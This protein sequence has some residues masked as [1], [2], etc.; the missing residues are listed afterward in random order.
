MQEMNEYK[1]IS[2]LIT[3]IKH[4]EPPADFTSRVMMAIRVEAEKKATQLHWSDVFQNRLHAWSDVI[5]KSITP[6][7]CSFYFFLTAIYFIAGW[8]ILY[9]SFKNN[10]LWHVSNAWIHVLPVSYI[11]AAGL[12][13]LSGIFILLKWPKGGAVIPYFLLGI[14]MYA[15]GNALTASFFV[16]ISSVKL[17]ISGFSAAQTAIA[18]ILYMAVM[19]VIIH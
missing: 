2:E 16:D 3:N 4:I 19:K 17:V 11:F 10:G 5:V 12:F 14:I 6:R 13:A 8:F 15:L 9:T 1:E 7:E 18:V